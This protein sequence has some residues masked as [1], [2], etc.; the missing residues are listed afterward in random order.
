MTSRCGSSPSP[1]SNG[2][3]EPIEGL[4]FFSLVDAPDGR[5]GYVQRV[6]AVGMGMLR[7]EEALELSGNARVYVSPE[8]RLYTGAGDAPIIQA[9]S[10]RDDA[11][12][13]GGR[14]SLA[15][16]GFSS[17]PFAHVFL[18]E[19]RVWLFGDAVVEWSTEAMALQE[20]P[21]LDDTLVGGRA[22]QAGLGVVRD[23]LVFVPVAY[24]PFPNVDDALHVLVFDVGGTFVAR[25]EDERCQQ[26]GSLE[27]AEDGT[28]YVAS[29]SGFRLPDFG[30][31]VLAGSCVLRILP[32]DMDFD[33]SWRFDV[34]TATDGRDSTGFVYEGNGVAYAFV[35][36][37]GR[38]P[39]GAEAQPRLYYES[40]SSRWWRFDLN[41]R[42]AALV[43]GLPWVA[44][45]SG[46]SSVLGGRVLVSTPE[47]FPAAA[48]RFWVLGG[49][50]PE[51]AFEFMGRGQLF[52][53]RP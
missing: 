5:T 48:N 34:R 14:V 36:H 2:R 9:L 12:E 32:G 23:G 40:A 20:G 16:F 27:L 50:A 7:N 26:T 49:D 44:S 15:A 37:P 11:W 10:L 1:T 35:L 52:E 22:P 38:V 45:G 53:L 41:D 25:I 39:A 47:A 18:S 17:A 46:I 6:P 24:A 21:S 8:G 51:P 33:R 31:D 4:L 19:D 28:I 42:T 29:D 30:S 13:F 43:E 3:G